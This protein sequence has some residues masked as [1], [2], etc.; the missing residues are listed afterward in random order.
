MLWLIPVV[1][2]H[3]FN[4]ELYGHDLRLL[5]REERLEIEYHLEVPFEVVQKELQVLLRN[6][7]ELTMGALRKKYLED[8]YQSI[9]E[10]LS[11]QVD[12]IDSSWDWFAPMTDTLKKEDQFLIFSLR[13]REE[14]KEGSHQIS[15]LNRN[16][17]DSLS[18][19]RTEIWYEGGVWIDKADIQKPMHWSKEEN[20]REVR[21][22]IRRLPSLWGRMEKFWMRVRNEQSQVRMSF[23]GTDHP[24]RSFGER[25]RRRQISLFEGI[26]VVFSSLL[27]GILYPFSDRRSGIGWLLICMG[28]G[29]LI[30][31]FGDDRL[32]IASIIGL[33]GFR[34]PLL[35]ILL[36]MQLCMPLWCCIF[37]V[38]SLMYRRK[39]SYSWIWTLCICLA[40]F[41]WST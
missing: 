1:F 11:L 10:D 27:M 25:A 26:G 9:A 3:P 7:Q 13:L 41:A 34:Y 38:P 30:G 12:G 40:F 31:S 14:L 17:E 5:F 20:M 36:W 21:L 32:W 6:N 16:H 33:L 2:S 24:Q 23:Q 4:A 19:Y 37:A 18:I 22:S 35:T 29:I 8:R 39:F 28:L 15:I